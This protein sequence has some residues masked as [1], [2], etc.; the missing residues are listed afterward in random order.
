MVPSTPY[1]PALGLEEE[2][3]QLQLRLQE[4]IIIMVTHG[5]NIAVYRKRSLFSENKN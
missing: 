1:V 2:K 5:D 3:I 4:K